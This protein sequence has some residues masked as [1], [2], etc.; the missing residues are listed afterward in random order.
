MKRRT[1][2]GTALAFAA[3][4]PLFAALRREAVG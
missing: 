2:L 1:F 4:S 3:G